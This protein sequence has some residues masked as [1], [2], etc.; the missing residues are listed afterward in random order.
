MDVIISGTENEKKSVMHDGYFTTGKQG[1][2]YNN[3]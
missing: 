3:K 1:A 2:T